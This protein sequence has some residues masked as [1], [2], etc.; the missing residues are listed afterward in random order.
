MGDELPVT[1]V[2]PAYRRPDMVE[3]A[4]RSVLRQRL[5]PAELLVVDDASG[6][7]TG[8]RAA[9]LGARVLTHER[10]RGEGAA[11]NTGIHAAEH[12]WIALLDC[13]DEWLPAHLETVWAAR[14]A[15]ALVGAAALGTGAEPEHHRVY[16]WTGRR[17]RLLRGPADVAVPE[18]KLTPSAVL[19]RRPAMLAAGGFRD[20]PRAAD[21]DMWIRMLEHGSGLALS[22]VTA[23]YHLHPG[24][25]STDRGP[26]SEAHGEV[27]R[28]YRD[29]PWCTSS[30]LRRHEGAQAWD[31]GRAAWA[32]GASGLRTLLRL[33]SRLA[34]PQR[35]VGVAELLIG[36]FRGRRRAAR[37][38]PGA[39]LAE[40]ESP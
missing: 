18:N 12:D 13:D 20:L 39:L 11:R 40:S 36:R 26:M 8:E 7:G 29:R 35:A 21:L 37:L 14:G 38:A 16:G 25:V 23:L 28:A 27:L 3:R 30:V 24:Q 33:V 22:R 19:L 5:R 10:N 17:P 34:R 6:D 4:V 9:R 2:I 15:H 1:V 32:G 31:E